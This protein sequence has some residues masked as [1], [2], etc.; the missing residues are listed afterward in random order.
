MFIKGKPSYTWEKLLK[1]VPKE[2]Y[3]EIKVFIKQNAD[4]LLNDK[5]KDYEIELL[6]GK[7]TLFLQNYKSLLE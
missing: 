1:K 7:H 4:I 2:Y 3:L 6:E 5:P